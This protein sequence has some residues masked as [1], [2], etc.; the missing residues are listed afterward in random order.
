MVTPAI[1]KSFF[2]FPPS[3]SSSA[4]RSLLNI[5]RSTTTFRPSTACCATRP[6]S[7]PIIHRMPLVRLPH[8]PSVSSI[9][10]L[11]AFFLLSLGYYQSIHP[12]IVS[13]TISYFVISRSISTNI[14]S[15]VS[16][17]KHGVI[18]DVVDDFTPTT[19]ISIA[20]PNA[21]KEVSLGN[22]L[23]P[24]DA[25]EKPT[26]QITPEGTDESQTYTI[27]LTDPDAPSR[28]NPEWSEFCHWIV[29]DVK[30]PSLETLS[31]AQTAEAASVNLSDAS[32]LV[33]YAGP[34]P[35]EKTGKHRYVF[36]LYRNEGSKKLEGPSRR[37]KW[38]NDDYRKGARQWS[39]KYG[40][41]LVGANFFFAQ[42][43]KQ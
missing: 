10:L 5:T 18:P 27:V 38:G 21:N 25:Q 8:T 26:I 29:T 32:E 42:N 3:S 15:H 41:S 16:L 35:P 37:R 13:R 23:K 20:Y 33:E 9:P 6:V 31:S 39:D 7:I 2:S 11:T 4:L 14:L 40:L 24:E 34:T 19:M 1:G 22:T 30:L 36:L 28:D 43:S 17:K 12:R